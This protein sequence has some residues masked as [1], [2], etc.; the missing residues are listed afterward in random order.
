MPLL[1]IHFVVLSFWGGGSFGGRELTCITRYMPIFRHPAPVGIFKSNNW[2][3][4]NGTDHLV[5]NIWAKHAHFDKWCPHSPT[6]ISHHPWH[7]DLFLHKHH[8]CFTEALWSDTSPSTRSLP[9]LYAQWVCSV[10]NTA[11][12][13]EREPVFLRGFASRITFGWKALSLLCSLI[14]TWQDAWINTENN[15]AFTAAVVYGVIVL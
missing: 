15:Y 12:T 10:L 7:H 1:R 14:S 9:P 6:S 3:R 4:G 11:N 8:C 2:I 13:A 5:S